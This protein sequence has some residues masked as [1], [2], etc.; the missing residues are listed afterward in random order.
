MEAQL[1]LRAKLEQLMLRRTKRL[2]AHQASQHYAP[3]PA[4]HSPPCLSAL[5]FILPVRLLLHCRGIKLLTALS[6]AV[7]PAPHDVPHMMYGMMYRRCPRSWTTSS[8]V[9]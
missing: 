3:A 5:P 6:S 4:R 1:D 2:I 9:S 7:M 8:S